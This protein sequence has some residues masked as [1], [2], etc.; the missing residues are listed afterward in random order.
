MPA[1]TDPAVTV[2]FSVKIDNHD[3][4]SFQKC[5]GLSLEVEILQH[6]EGGMNSFVHQLPGRIKYSNVKFTRSLNADSSKIAQ[7]FARMTVPIKRSNAEIIVYTLDEKPVA[8][9]ELQGVIPVRWSGPNLDVSSASV[10]TET[11]EIA[12]HGFR[13]R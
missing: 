13:I 6:E 11:L 10:A 3:L 8:T 4:G 9:W 1:I 7:W 5:E 2:K 12:H